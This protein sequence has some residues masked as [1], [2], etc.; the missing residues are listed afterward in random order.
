[1]GDEYHRVTSSLHPS[2]ITN[3]PCTPCSTR[4]IPKHPMSTKLHPAHANDGQFTSIIMHEN[5]RLRKRKKELFKDLLRCSRIIT[6][7]LRCIRNRIVLS[8]IL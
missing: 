2:V 3:Y 4:D 1:M 7:Q 8:F 6:S 5:D